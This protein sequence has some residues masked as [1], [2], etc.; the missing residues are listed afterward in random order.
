MVTANVRGAV[1]AAGVST[2]TLAQAAD[3]PSDVL[4]A[5]MAGLE[6]LTIADLVNVGGFL[7]SQP[8]SFLKGATS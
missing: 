6:E 1:N 4:D 8:T 7:R 2:S 5:R 3:V